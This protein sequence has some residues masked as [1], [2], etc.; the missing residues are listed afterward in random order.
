MTNSSLLLLKEIG[1]KY[2]KR[3]PFRYKKFAIYVNLIVNIMNRLDELESLTLTEVE[4]GK[5]YE[6]KGM[7]LVNVSTELAYTLRSWVSNPLFHPAMEIHMNEIHMKMVKILAHYT[8]QLMICAVI[9]NT[10][11]IIEYYQ[12]LKEQVFRNIDV[13][14][15]GDG[16]FEI[17]FMEDDSEEV[18]HG[19][20]LEKYANAKNDETRLRQ[21]LR[22]EIS[23]L[24][25]IVFHD[26]IEII[27]GVDIV[28]SR[29][30]ESK[31]NKKEMKFI[32]T[33][34]DIRPKGDKT[35]EHVKHRT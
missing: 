4:G 10:K 16:R 5:E 35:N 22:Q 23:F 20:I 6:N 34:T 2:K 9:C 15:I 13:E 8:Q 32:V 31:R 26:Y 3:H 7:T 33:Y 21:S 30:R 17:E 19:D 27:T 12:S 14:D 25:G 18:L 28:G 11:N 29:K 24:R 1:D